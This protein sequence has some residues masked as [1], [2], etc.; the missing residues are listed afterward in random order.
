M[1]NLAKRRVCE[2]PAGWTCE[3]PFRTLLLR[4]QGYQA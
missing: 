3:S 1:M 4:V 2:S